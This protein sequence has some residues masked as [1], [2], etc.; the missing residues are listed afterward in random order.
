MR[1]L[2]ALLACACACVVASPAAAEVGGGVTGPAQAAASKI[3]SSAL[4]SCAITPQTTLH[5][6]GEGDSGQLA[7]GNEAN[8]G[9]T[10]GSTT[11]QVFLGRGVVPAQ[12]SSGYAHSCAVDTAGGV[13]CWGRNINGQAGD[14]TT[15]EYLGDDEGERPAR[16]PLPGGFVAKQVA[17][18]REHTCALSTA[19]A[20]ACWGDN[21]AGQLGGETVGGVRLAPGLV[22]LPS[23]AFSIATRDSHTCV[24]LTPSRE[25]RCWGSNTFAESG[26]PNGV[27]SPPVASPTKP[28]TAPGTFLG[29]STGD[30]FTCAITAPGRDVVCWGE[31]TRGQLA[32]GT[33]NSTV[34]PGS[35]ALQIN[36]G[37]AKVVAISTGDE[38]VCALTDAGAVRCWGDNPSGMLGGGFV[39]NNW[40]DSGGAASPER[41]PI[42]VALGA[43]RTAVALGV[44]GDHTCALL[45]TGAPLC[46]GEGGSGQ[47]ANGAPDDTN[48]TAPSALPAVAFAADLPDG[49]GDGLPDR[50]DAC[51]AAAG[52]A[53]DGCPPP[54]AP[55]Q[56]APQQP[57]PQQ[58]PGV[59]PP[60]VLP[61]VVEPKARTLKV[62]VLL[63]R[64][65]GVKSC[66]KGGTASVTGAKP[67][68]KG[69]VKIKK[70][71]L[72]SGKVRCAA[73][74]TLLWPAAPAAG[75]KVKVKVG[76]KGLT[77]RTITVKVTS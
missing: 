50:Y 11:V 9:N 72:A 58:P 65:P 29:V 35:T 51:P 47:R 52:A 48:A 73:T 42:T 31:G 49:D 21:S 77:S 8:V 57:A 20:V 63:K 36:L 3:A 60:E 16:V 53:D 32:N 64:K 66:P 15:S 10:A 74:A 67:A 43:G 24:V 4:G 13:W 55:Q 2:F 41:V 61:P 71:K 18:G 25:L 69:A 17:A 23:A 28:T 37:G 27:G 1:L 14:G 34:A 26:I 33:G 76:G 19:G 54:P 75:T 68:F 44:G 62:S 6:W 5:C 59:K 38:S 7:T 12:V 45:S 46:W 70:R 30:R 22:N 40:G 39:G 56:P